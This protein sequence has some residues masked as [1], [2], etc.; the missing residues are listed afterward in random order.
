MRPHR[1]TLTAFG[2]FPGTETVDFDALAEA[3]L[4]LVHGPTGAGKTTI[5]DALCFALYGQVPGQRNS[6]R[7]LRCDHAAPTVGPSVTLEVSIRG[8]LLRIQRSPAWQRPKLRGT[9]FTEEKSKVVLSEWQGADW[10]GLT[11]R[12]DEAG[13]LVGGLLG[14][15]ADQFCQVAMLPQGDFARFLRAD[16]DERSKLLERL[17]TVKIFTS[18]ESWLAEHRKLAWRAAQELRQEV[19]FAIKRVEEAAGDALHASLTSPPAP[20]PAPAPASAPVTPATSPSTAPAPASALVPTPA[21][22]PSTA[23]AP[24]PASTPATAPVPTPATGPAEVAAGGSGGQE[25][26]GGAGSD[27]EAPTPETDPLRWAGRCSTPRGP[28]WRGRTASTARR[29]RSWGRHGCGSSGPPP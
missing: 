4:F 18:A 29:V 17:F 1:L 24:T 15:N 6:A 8:R 13:D 11:T 23:P 28:S 27:G 3:G 19:D 7:S 12:L 2:S 25:G 5:L 21:T 9:G 14:M 20:T 22:S 10:H 16:G 26:D